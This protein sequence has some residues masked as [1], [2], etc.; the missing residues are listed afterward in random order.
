M[1]DYGFFYEGIKAISEHMPSLNDEL[2]VSII[3]KYSLNE[4]II[5]DVYRHQILT[6][7]NCITEDSK[8]KQYFTNTILYGA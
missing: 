6:L 8:L 1:N 2:I 4:I 3:E 7:I 5:K